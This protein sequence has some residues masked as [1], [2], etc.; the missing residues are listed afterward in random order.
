[1]IKKNCVLAFVLTVLSFD[2]SAIN[3]SEM[4]GE[5]LGV[6]P[7][8]GLSRTGAEVEI[9]G[10]RESVTGY[11]VGVEYQWLPDKTLKTGSRIGLKNINADASNLFARYEVE[12]NI[13]TIGQSVSYDFDLDGSVLRPFASVDVGFGLAKASGDV[14]GESFESDSSSLPYASASIGARYLVGKYV[15]FIQGGYQYAKV[16]DMG[17]QAFDTG[18]DGSADYSG[19]YVTV[20]LGM[21]F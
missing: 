10:E 1:M 4:E 3:L 9:M 12:M 8:I 7:Y 18:V 20:G 6:M 5:S 11:E 14:F 19:T 21:I 2:S 16:S 17:F 15:P 13:L